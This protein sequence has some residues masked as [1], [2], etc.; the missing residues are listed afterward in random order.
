MVLH[1]VWLEYKY[2]LHPLHWQIVGPSISYIKS[3]YIEVYINSGVEYIPLFPGI[4]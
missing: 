2:V 4:I 3:I 1:N